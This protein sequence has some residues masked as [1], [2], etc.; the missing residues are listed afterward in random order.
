M[1]RH[2]MEQLTEQMRPV[3]AGRFLI[4]LPAAMDVS[5]SHTFIYGFWVA[6]IPESTEA[7]SERMSAREAEIHAQPNERGG[8]N[9]EKVEVVAEPTIVGKIFRFGRTS[10]EGVENRQSV[11]YVNVALEGYVHTDGVTFTFK[12]DAMDPDREGVLG[13]IIAKLR[14]VAPNEIPSA[15]G[16]CFGRGMLVDPV[17]VEWTEGAALFAGFREQPDLA[18]AFNTRAGLDKDPNDP[19]RLAR[20]ARSDAE[21]PLW[22]R[23]LLKKLRIGARTINGIAGEEVLERGMELSAVPVYTFDWEAA[24]AKD[25]ALVPAMH[26]E[27]STAHSAKAGAPPVLS[28]LSEDVLVQ[29]WGKIS[30]SIRVRP[31]PATVT[32]DTGA[33]ASR[34]KRGDSVEAGERCP[35]SGWWRCGDGGGALKVLGGQH[36][37]FRKGERLPQALLLPPQSVWEKIR[38][39]QPSYEPTQPT[40]WALIDRRSKSR[41]TPSGPLAAAVVQSSAVGRTGDT[42]GV[43]ASV[44]DFVGTGAPC[45]ASGWWQCQE[46]RHSMAPAGLHK[47]TSCQLRRSECGSLS[48]GF[49]SAESRCFNAGADGNLFGCPL[50]LRPS[51]QLHRACGPCSLH[52]PATREKDYSARN[53]GGSKHGR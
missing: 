7:F 13:Q 20:N 2:K 21:M 37:F 17:P 6:A 18:V 12:T 38:G 32:P 33:T 35:E 24:G 14:A 42:S 52:R 53:N 46:V 50:A 19:G 41:I 34:A 5:Y 44:G 8:R 3:C 43:P 28:F 49:R 31:T 10:V 15:P 9:M 16:F 22:Q 40:A 36:Q 39:V 48:S 4:D 45:P 23:P 11:H 26:L 30:G 25:N 51:G 1:S 27:L 29:L 47:E